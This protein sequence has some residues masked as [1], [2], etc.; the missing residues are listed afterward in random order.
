MIIQFLSDLREKLWEINGG[1]NIEVNIFSNKYKRN[2]KKDV[3]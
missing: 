3:A 2:V 1:Q